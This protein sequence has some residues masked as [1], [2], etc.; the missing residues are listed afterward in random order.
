MQKALRSNPS[1]STLGGGK[2]PF[3][4]PTLRELRK[5]RSVQPGQRSLAVEHPLS[6]REVV[7]S[8]PAAGSFGQADSTEVVEY[9]VAIVVTRVRFPA[10]ARGLM[11][12]WRQQCCFP[13]GL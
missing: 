1:G 10:D 9:N 7:G 5:G 6:K 11:Q 4:A 13:R 12:I 2:Q 8:N 3:P